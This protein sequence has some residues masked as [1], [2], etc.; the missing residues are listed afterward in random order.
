[1]TGGFT[2]ASGD[3]RTVEYTSS[4]GEA[5]FCYP[6]GYDN[7]ATKGTIFFPVQ[8]TFFLGARTQRNDSNCNYPLSSHSEM[9][10]VAKNRFGVV[11]FVENGGNSQSGTGPVRCVRN[12]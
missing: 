9:L 2:T 1:M 11:G 4:Y 8:D 10:N 12:R 5:R 7:R 6:G 3:A